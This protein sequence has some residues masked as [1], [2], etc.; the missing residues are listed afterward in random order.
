MLLRL[1]GGDEGDA[2]VGGG[3]HAVGPMP[4]WFCGTSFEHGGGGPGIR[5]QGAGSGVRDRRRAGKKRAARGK[6]LSS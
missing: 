3:V 6:R 5:C 2:E 1:G 4:V